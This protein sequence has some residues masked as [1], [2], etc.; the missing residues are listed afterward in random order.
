VACCGFAG[1]KGLSQPELNQHALREVATRQQGCSGGISA[2]RTCQIGL[3][4]HAGLVYD[5]VEVWLDRVS[6]PDPS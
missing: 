4:T 3:S 1:D 6:M 5:G 2:S